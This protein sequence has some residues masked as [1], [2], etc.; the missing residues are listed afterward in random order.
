MMQTHM[1][2]NRKPAFKWLGTKDDLVGPATRLRISGTQFQSQHSSQSPACSSLSVEKT[3]RGLKRACMNAPSVEAT[4][5]KRA[6][7]KPLQPRD[8]NLMTPYTRDVINKPV[9]LYPRASQ[10]D[11]PVSD[12]RTLS[13][14]AS[15][16]DAAESPTA[17]GTPVGSTGK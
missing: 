16:H 7:L 9:P 6:A 10:I 13:L 11:S 17:R 1:A 12:H 2:E 4:P 14:A 5:S 15:L 8:P 3:K